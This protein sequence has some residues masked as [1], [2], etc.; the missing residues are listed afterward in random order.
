MTS[1][2][3]SFSLLSDSSTFSG[4]TSTRNP[5]ESGWE[6]TT[7]FINLKVKFDK[8]VRTPFL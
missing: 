3:D 2:S 7:F 1:M 4:V 6:D 8:G 5:V